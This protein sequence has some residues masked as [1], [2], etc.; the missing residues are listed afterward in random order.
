MLN[1][2]ISTLRA[3]LERKRAWVHPMYYHDIDSR[4]LNMTNKYISM[5]FL[6]QSLIVNTRKK[7]EE[8]RQRFKQ[9]L[10]SVEEIKKQ[11]LS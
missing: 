8:T 9:S 2:Q 1:E 3:E 5:D 7:E 6:Y 10:D 4:L 11:E